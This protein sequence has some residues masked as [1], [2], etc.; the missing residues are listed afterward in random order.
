MLASAHTCFTRFR[1]SLD[2]NV[3]Y[4]VTRYNKISLQSESVR[5]VNSKYIDIDIAEHTENIV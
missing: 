3:R 1:Y 5:Y 4:K 2:V